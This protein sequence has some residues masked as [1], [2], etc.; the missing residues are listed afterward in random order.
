MDYRRVIVKFDL[1]SRG[2]DEGHKMWIIGQDHSGVPGCK[3]ALAPRNDTRQD[4]LPGKNA[5]YTPDPGLGPMFVPQRRGQARL[6]E[7]W[8]RSVGYRKLAVD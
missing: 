1:H 7:H 3:T 8:R 5:D 2:T 4:N 6:V